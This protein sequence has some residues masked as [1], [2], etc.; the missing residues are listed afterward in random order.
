MPTQ[1]RSIVSESISKQ[2]YDLTAQALH[3]ATAIAIVA[4]FILIQVVEGMPKGPER[5]AMMALHK[6]F[7]VLAFALVVVRAVWRHISRPPVPPA[8]PG[9]MESASRYTHAALY[10]LMVLVPLVGMVMSWAGGRPIVFF[11][12]F[13]LPNLVPE[14][15]ALKKGAEEVHELLGNL[16]LI[17]AG[18]HAAAALVHQYVLKDG[19]LTRMLPWGSPLSRPG[20]G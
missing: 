2:R 12:L 14:S 13:T 10:A 18:L 7:G 6:S 5:S 20:R 19:L 4:A 8:M 11:N 9:W 1:G 17:L 3:W 16:I 15:Q